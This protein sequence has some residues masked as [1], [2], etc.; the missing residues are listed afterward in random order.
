[1]SRLPVEEKE[2]AGLRSLGIIF[3]CWTAL[4]FRFDIRLSALSIVVFST[5]CEAA[6]E[7]RQACVYYV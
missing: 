1:M 4:R 2:V 3:I 5:F 6:G 7:D